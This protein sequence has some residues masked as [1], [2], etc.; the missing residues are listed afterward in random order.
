MSYRRSSFL[1]A[2]IVTIS[3]LMA[4]PSATCAVVS[5]TTENVST[6]RATV[7]RVIGAIAVKLREDYVFPEKGM[8]AAE[9][10]EKALDVTE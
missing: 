6:D 9:A 1:T 10:L 4:I 5:D 7:R 2:R 8:Q 3:T